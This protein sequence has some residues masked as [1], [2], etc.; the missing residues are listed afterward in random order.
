M[1]A[2]T[3]ISIMDYNTFQLIQIKI[4]PMIQD[5]S[6]S[7]KT[8]FTAK[9]VQANTMKLEKNGFLKINKKGIVTLTPAGKKELKQ[10][11]KL[12]DLIAKEAN[13]EEVVAEAA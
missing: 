6:D 9:K 4:K 13:Q 1:S 5:L 12:I 8:D 11:T 10:I 7:L 3:V 2:T